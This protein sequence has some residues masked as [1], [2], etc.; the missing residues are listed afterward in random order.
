M[1]AIGLVLAGGNAK[2]MKELSNKRAVAAMPVGGNFR[3]I[4]FVLSNMSNSHVQKVAVLTQFNS[5]SLNEHLNSSKWWDFGRKQGGLV[6]YTPTI[7]PTNS[8]WYRGTIDSIYQNMTYLRH[9]HEPYVIIAQGDGI[10]KLDYNKVLEYHIEKNADITVVCK[11]MDWVDDISRYGVVSTDEEG[12]ITNL[13]EKPVES[14][15]LFVNCGIY[16]I[17]RRLLME[18]V[19]KAAIEEKNDFVND[20]LVRYRNYK[21]IF[22][23]NLTSYWNNIS[24]VPAYYKTNMDFLKPEVQDEFYRDYPGIRTKVEDL[25]PAKY[26]SGCNVKNSLVSSGSIVNGTVEN[27][28]VFKKA[29]IGNGVVIKNSIILND[30]Y[31]GDNTVIENCIVESRGT[32]SANKQYIG[33]PE[34]IR[35]VVEEGERYSI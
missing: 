20:I 28:V 2:R 7:T 4:D 33:T 5:R 25:P 32:I 23:Y 9:S 26:N 13:E 18:L 21:K 12:R 22:A 10:Y 8:D 1:K 11:H 14:N 31:I 6:V 19:E 27:S 30:V 16:V 15:N 3:A 35:I 34:D 17:R 29:Y 24:S